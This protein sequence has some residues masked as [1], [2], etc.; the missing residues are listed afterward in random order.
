MKKPVK[1]EGISDPQTHHEYV[2]DL[3]NPAHPVLNGPVQDLFLFRHGFA[4]DLEKEVLEIFGHE[5]LLPG[6]SELV[7]IAV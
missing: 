6:P 3:F 7:N 2:I 1:E 4:I 5:F